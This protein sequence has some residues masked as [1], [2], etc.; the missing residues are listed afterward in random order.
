MRNIIRTAL[1]LGTLASPMI[2]SADPAPAAKDSK[3]P[4]AK[5]DTS[6]TDAKA[7][8]AKDSKAP[9]ADAKKD[10]AKPATK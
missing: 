3:T 1:V 8:A 5:T 7:P 2:A 10:A 6:K 4:A 9:A